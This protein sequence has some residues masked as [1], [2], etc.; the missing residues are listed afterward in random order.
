MANLLNPVHQLTMRLEFLQGVLEIAMLCNYTKKQL[1]E[2]QESLLEELVSI[3]NLM[4]RIYEKTGN[5]DLAFS[6]WEASMETLRRWLS[7]ITGIKIK[8]V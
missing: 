4:F 6:A 1:E 8:Y 3:D 2:L 5:R 7:L